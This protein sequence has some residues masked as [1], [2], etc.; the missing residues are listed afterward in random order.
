MEQSAQ[1]E[2]PVSAKKGLSRPLIIILLVTLFLL[3]AGLGYYFYSRNILKNTSPSL[4]AQTSQKNT[5]N[6]S[7]GGVVEQVSKQSITVREN[8]LSKVE[9]VLTNQTSVVI[10][11][12]NY[13]TQKQSSNSAQLLYTVSSTDVGS[14]T[15]IKIGDKVTIDLELKDNQYFAKRV[16][17]NREKK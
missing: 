2:V 6:M 15:D 14:S 9:V 7:T 8:P 4:P 17:V 1:P 16:V 12:V 11:T 13:P 10:Q 3:L 5:Q